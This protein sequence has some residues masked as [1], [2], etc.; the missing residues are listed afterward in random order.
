[1]VVRKVQLEY[2]Y[3]SKL[4]APSDDILTLQRNT[5]SAIPPNFNAAFS[6]LQLTFPRISV[7]FREFPCFSFARIG[8]I[9]TFAATSIAHNGLEGQILL[10]KGRLR[11]LSSAVE[12]RKFR[13]QKKTQ[14]QRPHWVYCTLFTSHINGEQSLQYH[15]TW[16]IELLILRLGNARARRR[17]KRVE[18][19]RLSFTHYF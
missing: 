11:T 8:L 9:T 18:H 16:A 2:C 13:S 19:P 17:G 6:S 5:F 10:E 15:A 1:M 14:P 12:S 7:P 3:E 4:F